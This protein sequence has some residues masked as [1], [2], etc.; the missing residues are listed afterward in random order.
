M[1]LAIDFDMVIHDPYN[2]SKGFKMGVPI[3]DA[4]ESIRRLHQLGHTIVIHPVWADTEKKRQAI[5][6]WL[7]Y[8]SIPFDD[9]TSTKPDADVYIDDRGYRFTDWDST[10]KF[11]EELER[12]VKV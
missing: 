10:I 9:I 4:V 11:L 7:T 3:V 5:I 2:V 6:D 8:F 12:S 1:K